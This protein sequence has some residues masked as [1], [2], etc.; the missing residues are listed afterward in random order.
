LPWPST[1]SDSSPLWNQDRDSNNLR[2]WN[3]IERYGFNFLWPRDR[4]VNGFTQ[5]TVT[6]R[7]GNTQVNPIFASGRTMDHLIVAS[8]VGVPDHLV[9]KT[10]DA[11]TNIQVPLSGDKWAASDWDSVV[12][13][14]GVRDPHMIESIAERTTANLTKYGYT[15]GLT[16]YKGYNTTS[17]AAD[18]SADPPSGQ[19]VVQPSTGQTVAYNGNGGE[20]HMID[21]VVSSSDN[22]PSD[23]DFDDLQFACM[24]TRSVTAASHDCS[25]RE[26]WAWQPECSCTGA[27]CATS[28]R[29]NTYWGNVDANVTQPY[30]KAY[31]GLRYLRMIEAL[32]SSGYA[33]SIC[34][35]SFEPAMIGIVN[36]IRSV[37]AGQCFAGTVPQDADGTSNC[38]LLA[39][40]PAASI[41]SPTT[42]TTTN[43]C[44]ALGLCTP[45]A[46][47]CNRSAQSSF[48]PNQTSAQAAA[49]ITLDRNLGGSSMQQVT[50]ETDPAGS[51]NVIL[52]ADGGVEQLVCEVPQLTGTNLTS[53]TTDPSYALPSSM[54]AGWCYSNSAAS[55]TA[56]GCAAGTGELRALGAATTQPAG[57]GLYLE[58][59]SK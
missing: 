27:S 48:A 15:S 28:A 1:A 58:C 25:G 34:A 53:C 4:Y 18:L 50:A 14:L 26:T 52:A 59:H 32:G 35:P 16:E 45:G 23:G 17:G 13:P 24:G 38:I 57:S 55:L 49:E 7:F 47:G 22:S 29:A 40:I 36:K 8:I 43:A 46:A 41:K 44:E 11:A 42:I 20:R 19:T 10:L 54:T 5:A 51:G 56:F 3:Q 33:A 2:A 31:P 37:F 30:Y 21:F 6:D 39:T 9:P 12:G